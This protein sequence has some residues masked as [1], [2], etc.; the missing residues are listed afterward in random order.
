MSISQAESGLVWL[1]APIFEKYGQTDTSLGLWSECDTVNDH[2]TIYDG[3]G[4]PGNNI[5]YLLIL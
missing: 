5:Q 1:N 3:P 2:V 4:V